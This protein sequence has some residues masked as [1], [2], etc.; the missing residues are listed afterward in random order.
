MYNTGCCF[1]DYA[2]T[3]CLRTLEYNTG[4]LR[5]GVEFV[6]RLGLNGDMPYRWTK[7]YTDEIYHLYNRGVA[8]QKVFL[9]AS[10]YRRFERTLAYYQQAKP[11]LSFSLYFRMSDDRQQEVLST[12]VPSSKL[13][14]ILA[15]CLMPNHYHLIVKQITKDGISTFIRRASNSY[16]KY[17]NTRYERVGPLFQGPYKIKHVTTDEQLIHLSKYV[18]LNPVVASLVQESNLLTYL[19]SS[20]PQYCSSK[21][22]SGMLPVEKDLILSN[23]ESHSA[24]KEY[25]FSASHEREYEV[26]SDL[27]LD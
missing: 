10:D 15:Y 24:Y 3:R 1:L 21:R 19:H 4:C 22:Y 13:V 11:P 16:T 26:I 18:H 12:F 14:E 8:R 25:V 6:D 27:I 20:L 23:F 7:A 9:N 5:D 17:V 2:N